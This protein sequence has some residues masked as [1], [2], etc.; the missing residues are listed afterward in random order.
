MFFSRLLYFLD[1]THAETI[2][3]GPVT[4]NNNENLAKFENSFEND[5]FFLMFIG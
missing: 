5:I 1:G 3:S 2:P 4:D